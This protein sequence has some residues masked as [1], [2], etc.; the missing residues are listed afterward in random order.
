VPKNPFEIPAARAVSSTRYV[1]FGAYLVQNFARR[2]CPA[3][4]NVFKSL[5]DTL[6]HAGFRRQIE[7][8]KPNFVDDDSDCSP[9]PAE[10]PM[11]ADARS[12]KMEASVQQLG[13]GIATLQPIF[14]GSLTLDD[15]SGDR[16]FH[17]DNRYR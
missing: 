11:A 5:P 8:N 14:T 12:K 4:G 7:R 1:I 17:A 2:P 15:P 13:R 3:I 6:G 10:W 9:V 16:G